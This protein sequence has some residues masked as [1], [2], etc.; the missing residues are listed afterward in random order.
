MKELRPVTLGDAG[1]AVNASEFAG[2]GS[3]HLVNEMAQSHLPF[4]LT[5]FTTSGYQ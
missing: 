5:I 4:A 2:L 1:T 3:Q